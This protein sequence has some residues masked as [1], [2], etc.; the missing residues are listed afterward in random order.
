MTLREVMHPVT[1]KTTLSQVIKDMAGDPRVAISA[2]AT[3]D[4]RDFKID[5][6]MA[7]EGGTLLVGNSVLV[8]IEAELAQ[9]TE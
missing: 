6:N 5:W 8:S 7:L 1:L 9:Q 3:F 2:Q 4:K